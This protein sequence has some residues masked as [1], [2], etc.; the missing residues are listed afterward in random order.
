MPSIVGASSN[1][2]RT[3]DIQIK[4]PTRHKSKHGYRVRDTNLLALGFKS[5]AAYLKVSMWAIVRDL[6]FE[7]NG[8]VCINCKGHA[9]QIHHSSYDL[10]T[11]V[12]SCLDYLHPVCRD[13]HE[14][15]EVGENGK[16]SFYKANRA[17]GLSAPEITRE[18]KGIA[19]RLIKNKPMLTK[20]QRRRQQ[21]Q[22]ETTAA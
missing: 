19:R 11:L 21:Q 12:G 9:T 22:E 2:R 4:R 15:A 3:G 10:K 20:K 14:A 8:R 16:V 5:Y 6:A 17:M 13:C 1:R 18:E 7:K